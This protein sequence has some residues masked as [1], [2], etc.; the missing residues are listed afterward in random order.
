MLFIGITS[1]AF[2]ILLLLISHI[3]MRFLQVFDIF[4]FNIK[5]KNN[6]EGKKLK[7]CYFKDKT[8]IKSFLPQGI[9]TSE[10]SGDPTEWKDPRVSVHSVSVSSPCFTNNYLH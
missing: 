1:L 9:M 7:I 4:L 2:Y 8:R 5:F 3:Q 6:K 10:A